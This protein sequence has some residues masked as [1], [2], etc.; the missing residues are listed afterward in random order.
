MIHREQVSVLLGKLKGGEDLHDTIG[1][2]K[3]ISRAVLGGVLGVFIGENP[4]ALGLLGSL[5]FFPMLVWYI[6][7][8]L[9]FDW[10]ILKFKLSD[11]S[12]LLLAA[13]F[14]ILIGG[15]LDKE[16]FTSSPQMGIFGTLI[17]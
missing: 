15:I 10:M 8:F 4:I 13:I 11:R 1:M 16:F 6:F 5:T 2:M 9:T 3:L 17:S 7:L 14:A 12:F